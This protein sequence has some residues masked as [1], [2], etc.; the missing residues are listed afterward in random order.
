MWKNSK[1]LLLLCL[2]CWTHNIVAQSHW[3]FDYRL[4]QYDMT[5]Y[6]LL[7]KDGN[8]VSDLDDYEVAA[9]IGSECHGVAKVL[10]VEKDE[11]V[12]KYGY[13]RIYSNQ[14]DDEIVTFRVYQKTTEKES[15]L[16]E[17]ITFHSLSVVG[18]PSDPFV[19]S[20]IEKGDA[21]GDGVI[22][23]A[24]VTAIINHINGSTS[25]SFVLSAA[26]ANGDGS[27]N[28]ADVTAVINMINQ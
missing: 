15:T 9:F 14:A 12:K 19:L 13:L 5:V 18:M 22:N 24:D 6:F 25:G 7:E 26:D 21:N 11:V 27:I 20:I 4:F 17:S 8:A 3:S 1:L 16:S 10:E 28:I 23:I 2:L